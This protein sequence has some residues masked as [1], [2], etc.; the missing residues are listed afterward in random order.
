MSLDYN[1]SLTEAQ[2]KIKSAKT[3]KAVKDDI[4]KLKQDTANNLEEAKSDVTSTLNDIKD[5]K[6]RFQRQVKS[7]FE[8]LSP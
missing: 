3:Y 1:Q 7:Q 6:K 5:A 2:K 8:K 4:K